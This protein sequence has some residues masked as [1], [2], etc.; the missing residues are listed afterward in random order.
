MSQIVH[1]TTCRGPLIAPPHLAG[2]A[3]T[4][5]HCR[6]LVQMPLHEGVRHGE[7]IA[8][9]GYAG[10]MLQPPPVPAAPPIVVIQTHPP[11]AP[12]RQPAG[13]FLDTFST[14]SGI[15]VSLL[16]LLVVLP[17]GGL[18]LLGYWNESGKEAQLAEDTQMLRKAA[19]P[20]LELNGL[21]RIA[22]STMFGRT[23]TH[24]GLEGMAADLDGRL[25]TF[26][27]GFKSAQ[28]D[29][30]LTLEFDFLEIDG[31][32]VDNG[33]NHNPKVRAKRKVSDRGT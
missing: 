31:L 1:C 26:V 4:C 12:Q 32:L 27:I 13:K 17:C 30:Q 6:T 21:V 15:V 22:N 8:D 16:L 33:D 25:H 18:M 11:L 28:F 5:P 19:K 7:L 9:P 20:F 14:T 3:V 29:D 10:G 24:V 23:K 2:Q